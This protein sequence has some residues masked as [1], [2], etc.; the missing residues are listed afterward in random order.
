MAEPLI[1]G[2]SLSLPSA[3]I[4]AA[5]A[6]RAAEAPL[7]ASVTKR[8]G[9]YNHQLGAADR[10]FTRN[11]PELCQSRVHALELRHPVEPREPV[12]YGRQ[13]SATRRDRLRGWHGIVPVRA[14]WLNWGNSDIGAVNQ[15]VRLPR[16]KLPAA[17]KAATAAA[18]ARSTPYK[19]DDRHQAINRP[20]PRLIPAAGWF[21]RRAGLL[22]TAARPCRRL[23]PGSAGRPYRTGRTSHPDNRPRQ[24]TI[25]AKSLVAS[26]ET[27][28][29]PFGGADKARS[30]T[31][32]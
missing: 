8:V 24:R 19:I 7:P 6:D 16:P 18:L 22:M 30:P 10:A 12:E 26:R 31:T 2:T 17:A 25:A 28:D 14:C 13:A 3:T 29:G 9:T 21:R 32:V 20:G 5:R 27:A 15:T 4:A 1:I 23:G 11:H